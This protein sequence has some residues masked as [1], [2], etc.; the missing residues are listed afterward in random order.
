M[1]QFVGAIAGHEG[2]LR[3]AEVPGR[4][5]ATSR[6]TTRPTAW[7]FRRR[8]PSAASGLVPDLARTATLAPEGRG[9]PAGGDRPRGRPPRPVALS[10]DPHRQERGRAAAGGPGRRDQ[11]R[12]PRALADPRGQG[13]RRARRQRR[14][15]A[16]GHCR[17]GAGRAASAC[18][19]SPTRA[20][21][22]RTPPG[23]ARTRAATC[24]RPRPSWPRRSSSGRACWRCPRASVG[25]V[26]GDALA[27]KDEAALALGRSASGARGTGCRAIMARRRLMFLS[28]VLAFADSCLVALH[29]YDRGD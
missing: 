8:R 4:V 29:R 14:R 18:S 16:G 2:S 10:A 25:R 26:G 13:G 21:C 6:S 3:G 23:S 11:G 12:Q 24:W 20:S 17:D 27:L 5:A 1:G 15:P 7:P 22:R 9:R 19:S 28:N